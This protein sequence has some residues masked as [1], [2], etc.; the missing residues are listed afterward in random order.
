MTDGLGNLTITAIE[1]GHY[2]DAASIAEAGLGLA[3]DLEY[4]YGI[5]VMLTCLSWIA[6]DQGQYSRAVTLAEEAL[7]VAQTRGDKMGIACALLKLSD[8]V[9]CQGDAERA[10]DL[11]EEAL[12]LFRDLGEKMYLGFTLHNLGL[13]AM[14]RG[15]YDRAAALFEQGAR[16]LEEY[17][18]DPDEVVASMGMVARAQGDY[19]RAKELFARNLAGDRRLNHGSSW[20]LATKLEGT[21]GL[22]SC[23]GREEQAA[24][25]FGAADAIRNR[26]GTPIW[27]VY[28]HLYERDLAAVRAA[29]GDE[30]FEAAWEEGR[31][32]AVKEAVAYALNE[33]AVPR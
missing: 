16:L 25:L 17:G 14:I 6:R 28:R 24:R 7:G 19:D 12:S 21:A 22:V 23:Q 26:I 20:L 11:C 3:Q 30:C 13:A 27:P 15:E 33:V 5:N 31:A 4:G 8:A 9:Y 10:T 29:L 18:V 2:D 1:F 32:M